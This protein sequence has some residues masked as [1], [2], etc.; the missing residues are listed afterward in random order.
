MTRFLDSVLRNYIRLGT[1]ALLIVVCAGEARAQL[2]RQISDSSSVSILTTFPGA[3]VYSAWGHS[4]MRIQD[5]DSG[6]DAV[7]SYGT[8]DPARPY[9]IPRFVYGDMLYEISV[10][11]MTRF[12]R[13][14]DLEQRD[15]VEQV[16]HLSTEATAQMWGLLMENLREENKSYL[17]DFVYDN[18]STRL[19]DLLEAT[20]SIAL[21]ADDPYSATFR[22]MLDEYIHNRALLDL[23]IDLVLGSKL[24]SQ[25]DVRARTF[26]P[27]YL[28]DILDVSVSYDGTPLV[29][30]K[31]MLAEYGARPDQ[32]GLPWTIPFFWA[33]SLALLGITAKGYRDKTLTEPSRLDRW[34]LGVI[35]FAGLFLMIMW[36][37]THHTLTA[38][39]WNVAWALPTHFLVAARWKRIPR[40]RTYLRYASY[41]TVAILVLQ[42]FLAQSI[43]PPMLPV[44][45]ALA[46]RMW[47]VSR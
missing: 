3:P 1:T 5:P 9:F 46:I 39:N 41:W 31:R 35:G 23:G 43:P 2:P 11:P 6:I 34:L 44:V 38:M 20:G 19:I 45:I 8:F 26:L 37:F 40:L 30:Q 21:P 25:P 4:A 42:F 16:L 7:F 32:S 29:R 18:C 28:M 36:F 15:V 33:A 27:V 13:K 14:S 17:Y 47:V 24:D 10:E 22:E 12:M